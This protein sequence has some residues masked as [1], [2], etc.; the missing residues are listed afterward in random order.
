MER[1]IIN[2]YDQLKIR[3]NQLKEHFK[4]ETK[5]EGLSSRD[6][7]LVRAFVVLSHA[8]FENYFEDVALFLINQ[9]NDEWKQTN[10]ANYNLASLLAMSDKVEKNTPIQTIIGMMIGNYKKLI[11]DNHGIKSHNIRSMYKPIGYNID[12]FDS[13]FISDLDTFGSFRGQIAHTSGT[14]TTILLDYKT[15]SDRVDRI[16]NG[17]EQFNSDV[18]DSI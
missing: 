8:E 1:S 6:E 17:I 5:E 14:R 2:R 7:D 3:I 9:A 18:I 15:E 11:K 13:V 16:I 12:S 4:V 10:K